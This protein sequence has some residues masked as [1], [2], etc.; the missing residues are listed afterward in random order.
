MI[1]LE[2]EPIRRRLAGLRRE[3]AAHIAPSSVSHAGGGEDLVALSW[4]R[5]RV[6]TLSAIRYLDVGAADPVY[7]SNTYLFY[8][9]GGSGVL[10][11]P[12][13]RY[14]RQIRG[15]RPRDILIS[16]GAKF[17]DR[18][19]ADLLR[20]SSPLFNTFSP[21]QAEVVA[22]TSRGWG[23]GKGQSLNSRVSRPLRA[24]N[25]ILEEHFSSSPLHLLSIDTDGVNFAV[26]KSVD[27]EKFSP[28]VVCV[29]CQASL[30]EHLAVAGPRYELI[31]RG[32]DNFMLALVR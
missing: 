1:E 12:D 13:P 29:E 15:R 32:P 21:D 11:E 20:F 30:Q 31:Y 28:L 23:Q 25:D 7:L 2:I 5:D 27:F 4:L 18:E 19:S 17:D 10:V 8:R 24:M 22:Q 16:A 9:L 26:F 6:P 3:L 14:E